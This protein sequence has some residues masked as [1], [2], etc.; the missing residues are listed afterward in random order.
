MRKRWSKVEDEKLKKLLTNGISYKDISKIFNLK[1]SQIRT[2]ANKFGMQSSKF[3]KSIKKEYLCTTC[4]KT[5]LDYPRNNRKYCSSSCAATQNNKIYPKRSLEKQNK[6]VDCEKKTKAQRCLECRKVFTI[7]NYGT[8]TKGEFKSS[9][10]RH[11]YQKIRN[12]AHKVIELHS[13]I[14]RFCKICEYSL[15]VDLAHIKPIS[16]F[17]DS[18]LLNEINNIENLVYLCRNHH[19]EQE[20]GFIPKELLI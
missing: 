8:R 19:W 18:A 1:P 20:N 7:S 14:P 9:S 13:E 16:D 3:Q 6:C 11:K 5:F 15:H 2:R 12:H 10:A 4:K 17:E